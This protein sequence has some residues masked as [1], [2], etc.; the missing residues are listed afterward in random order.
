MLPKRFPYRI[1]FVVK[2]EIVTILCVIHA[3]RRKALWRDLLPGPS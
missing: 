2:G 3:K 1:V